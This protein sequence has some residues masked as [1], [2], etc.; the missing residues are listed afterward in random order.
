[1][2]FNLQ[3]NQKI[4]AIVIVSIIA[5]TTIISG[6]IIFHEGETAKDKEETKE[7]TPLLYSILGPTQTSF[8]TYKPVPIEITPE[9]SPY[10][11]SPNLK[12]VKNL[13][14]FSLTDEMRE[15]LAANGFVVIPSEIDQIYEIYKA[16]KEAVLPNFVTTDSVLHAYHILYDYV[17][18][19]M[20]AQIFSNDLEQ[21]TETLLRFSEAHYDMAS[22]PKI[23][24]AAKRNTAFFAVAL[25]LQ[26]ASKVIPS[27]VTDLVANEL[28]L[29]NAH[30][31]FAPSPIFGYLEDY[32]QYVARGHYTRSEELEHYFM[33]MMWYGRIMFRLEPGKTVQEIEMGQRET[34]QALLIVLEMNA[35]QI[36]GQNVT[37]LWEKI[38][39]PTTFFVGK[40]DD[41]SLREYHQLAQEVYGTTFTLTDLSD[42]AKMEEFIVQAK[43]LRSPKISSSFVLGSQDFENVTKGFR[44]MGQRFI[45]D[46]YM[47][48]ELVCDKVGTMMK[49]RLF[50][51]GLDIMAVL[52]SERAEVLLAD[53]TQYE[54]YETQLN[55]L[56]QGFSSLNETDWTQNLYWLWIYSLLPLLNVKGEGYP[57]FMQTPA[58]VDKELYTA[59]GSWAELRHDTILYAKQSYTPT[60]APWPE[61][62]PAMPKGYVEPNP[63]LYGRL[64]SLARMMQEGLASRQLHLE[65]FSWKLDQLE[66]L[67]L[68]LAKISEKELNNQALTKDEYELIHT[69]GDTL[70]DITTFPSAFA[71]Q[72]TSEAD[73]SMAIVADVHTD[74]NSGQVLEEGVGKAFEI[75]VLVEVEGIIQITFGGM[76]SYYEFVHPMSDRLTDESWQALLGTP[77][78]PGLPDWTTNFI[79]GSDELLKR[80]M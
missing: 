38:Y 71:D 17:L 59:L 10:R 46:S 13:N 53:E 54:N 69:I 50:P 22:D 41:L 26:N 33:A 21:L 58:W 78:E 80:R 18:R 43:V 68:A 70:E 27:L 64:A 65:E 79:V 72:F 40:T 60:A 76:F 3:I 47:F 29:I 67:L 9:A 57:V 52:G 15:K 37:E 66:S 20:E 39:E 48:Q 32:S 49:P 36:N 16:N 61:P 35:A 31:G 23:K 75:Y 1:M 51:K 11:I 56:Q 74:P 4:L 24:E 25:R 30:E 63:A 34:R 77:N 7:T 73:T 2:R 45:P 8:G 44:F 12:N 28:A 5:I 19:A 62:K 55:K 6:F 14:Q 42:D